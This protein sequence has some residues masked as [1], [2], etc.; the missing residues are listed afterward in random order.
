MFL[1]FWP[2]LVSPAETGLRGQTAGWLI[3]FTVVWFALI[4]LAWALPAA[5]AGGE[6]YAQAILW[7]QTADR[8]VNSFAHA[9]PWWWYLPWCTLWTR[10]SKSGKNQPHHCPT[11]I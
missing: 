4:A 7:G 10:T 8:V 11:S 5:G 3:Y 2:L 9:Q 6:M 1:F